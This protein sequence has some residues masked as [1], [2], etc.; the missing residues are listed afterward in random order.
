MAKR[1]TLYL[2]SSCN[3]FKE[4]ASMR[5][6][7]ATSNLDRVVKVIRKWIRNGDIVYGSEEYSKRK[8]LAMFDYAVRVDVRQAISDC[9]YC[10]MNEVI[11]GEEQ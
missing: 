3:I 5:L 1:Q 11:D 8:Q 9:S 6:I 4:W 10:F 7:V 2:L